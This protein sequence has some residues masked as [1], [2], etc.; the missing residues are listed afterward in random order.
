MLAL[1]AVR[2]QIPVLQNFLSQY[3]RLTFRITFPFFPAR[4]AAEKRNKTLRTPA[5]ENVYTSV[6]V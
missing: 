2:F 3:F 6:I 1:I 5:R 4:P